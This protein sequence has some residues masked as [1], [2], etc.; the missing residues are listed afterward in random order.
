VTPFA[1]RMWR[2]RF[3]FFASGS[4]PQSAGCGK[5]FVL[6]KAITSE[7]WGRLLICGLPVRSRHHGVLALKGAARPSRAGVLWPWTTL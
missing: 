2:R 3:G 6:P 7:V 5:A 4:S 1:H